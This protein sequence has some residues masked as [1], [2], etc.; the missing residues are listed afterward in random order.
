MIKWKGKLE[1]VKEKKK[2]GIRFV[3]MFWVMGLGFLGLFRCNVY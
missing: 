1:L 2:F 3:V